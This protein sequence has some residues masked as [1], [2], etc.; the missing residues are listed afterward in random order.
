MKYMRRTA[1][2]I[3]TDYKTNAQINNNTDFRQITVVFMMG[4]FMLGQ[5]FPRYVISDLSVIIPPMPHILSSIY[6][7]DA[8]SS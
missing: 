4:K 2:Y 1:G 7:T 6:H 3:W 5:V 8:L